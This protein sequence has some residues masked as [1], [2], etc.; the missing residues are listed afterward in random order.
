MQARIPV[1][2]AAPTDKNTVLCNQNHGQLHMRT[3]TKRRRNDL[4]RVNKGHVARRRQAQRRVNKRGHFVEKRGDE[5][6]YDEQGKE[7][8]QGATMLK[9]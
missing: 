4:H 6:T 7:S 9:Q 3:P 1:A 8:K 5:Y 2:R